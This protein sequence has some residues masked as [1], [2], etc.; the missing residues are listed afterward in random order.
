MLSFFKRGNLLAFVKQWTRRSWGTEAY[1]KG[2]ECRRHQRFSKRL[3]RLLEK[4]KKMD[5]RSSYRQK[6]RG[7]ALYWEIIISRQPYLL[8][9][10]RGNKG[11]WKLIK[12]IQGQWTKSASTSSLSQSPLIFFYDITFRPSEL[13]KKKTEC[14]RINPSGATS[15]S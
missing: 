7:F 10:S 5:R 13:I 9:S 4:I 1:S 12:C 2:V 3:P 6:Q 14:C 11:T 15:Q 8:F